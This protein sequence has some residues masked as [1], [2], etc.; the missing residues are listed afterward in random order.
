MLGLNEMIDQ[1][2]MA[3][4]VGWYVLVVDVRAWSC[5]EKNISS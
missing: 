2:A 5:L 1:L 4:S 3:N